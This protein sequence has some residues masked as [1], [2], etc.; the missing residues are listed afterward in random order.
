MAKKK[1]IICLTFFFLCWP[2]PRFFFHTVNEHNC[3]FPSPQHNM[4]CPQN[5]LFQ[6]CDVHPH[7]CSNSTDR[8][9]S[10]VSII[11]YKYWNVPLCQRR[12]CVDNFE[13]GNFW[14][15]GS[16]TFDGSVLF[17]YLETMFLVFFWF[18]YVLR[19]YLAGVIDKR[20]KFCRREYMSLMFVVTLTLEYAMMMVRNNGT[21]V[22]D[23]WGK[24]GAWWWW[25]VVVVGLWVVVVVDRCS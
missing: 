13:H 25:E 15:N 22:Y 7:A 3:Q 19:L 14:K 10:I 18:E 11:G 20:K 6:G 2:V 5:A 21:F 12:A 23:P 24:R 8:E 16:M 9:N 1:E 4:T 17:A